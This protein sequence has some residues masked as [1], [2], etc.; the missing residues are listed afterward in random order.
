MEGGPVDAAAMAAGGDEARH[1]GKVARW[2]ADRG[3]GFIEPADGA[4]HGTHS[5]PACGECAQPTD[6]VPGAGRP[7]GEPPA[8]TCAARHAPLYVPGPEG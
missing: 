2:T 4:L 1:G 6:W 5:A 3:F 7:D 8:A